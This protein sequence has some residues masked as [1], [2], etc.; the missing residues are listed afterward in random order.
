MRSVGTRRGAIARR[1]STLFDPRVQNV[2]RP[3]RRGQRCGFH[4]G[5]SVAIGVVTGEVTSVFTGMLTGV[6]SCVVSSVVA[7]VITGG[8]FG[9]MPFPLWAPLKLHRHL[10]GG[11]GTQVAVNRHLPLEG[12]NG[13]Y[14][15]LSG[16]MKSYG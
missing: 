7:G 9:A 13:G 2:P 16:D 4:S 14:R 12:A 15:H 6:V 5:Y 11:D 8:A 3:Q 10:S 1:N